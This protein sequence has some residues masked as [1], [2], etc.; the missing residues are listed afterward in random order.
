VSPRELDGL[1]RRAEFRRV[2]RLLPAVTAEELA[3][4][5][6]SEQ[7]LAAVYQMLARL[8]VLRHVLQL[9]GPVLEVA[10]R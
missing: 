10:A 9:L 1:L 8:P 2:Q 3:G 5:P 4:L 6:R 7:R